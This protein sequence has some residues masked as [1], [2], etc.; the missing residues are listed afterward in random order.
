MHE[1]WRKLSDYSLKP[2]ITISDWDLIHLT[3]LRG[4]IQIRQ[5][6]L[7]DSDSQLRV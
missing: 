6:G 4:K 3:D 5:L 2:L 7:Y 1:K